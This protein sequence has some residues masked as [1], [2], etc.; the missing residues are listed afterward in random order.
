MPI[1]TDFLSPYL[2]R[3]H[4]KIVKICQPLQDYLEIS[5]FIYYWIDKDGRYMGLSNN[6]VYFEHFCSTDAYKH[7]PFL[8]HPFLLRGGYILSPTT[9]DPDFLNALNKAKENAYLFDPFLIVNHKQDYY[10]G[11]AFACSAPRLENSRKYLNYLPLLYKFADYFVREAA[12]II[13]RMKAERF[14]M[15][16]LKG[17]AFFHRSP[18][19]PLSARDKIEEKFLAAISPLSARERECHDLFKQGHSAQATAAMLKLSRRTIEHY[20]ESIKEKLGCSSK[21][22][23]LRM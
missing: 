16:L 10:E 2:R 5:S 9:P 22:D 21:W 18:L 8:V 4:K 13:E 6:W 20:F 12:D 7:N 15:G 14:N 3:Y 19:L 17:E 1:I 23:L 11:F